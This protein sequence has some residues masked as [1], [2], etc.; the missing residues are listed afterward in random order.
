MGQHNNTCEG[1]VLQGLK[2][3]HSCYSPHTLKSSFDAS[4]IPY[5]KYEAYKGILSVVIQVSRAFGRLY[6]SDMGVWS[7][8]VCQSL[9]NSALHLRFLHPQS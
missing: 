5:R 4:G 2:A 9:H 1:V 8:I 7:G 3:G 6:A